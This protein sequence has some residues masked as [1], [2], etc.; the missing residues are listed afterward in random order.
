LS[1]RKSHDVSALAKILRGDGQDL[2][3]FPD[4]ED[5]T[6]FAVQYRYEAYDSE[7]EIDRDEAIEKTRTFLAHVQGILNSTE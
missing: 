3:K 7:D 5:Y 1:I 6:V 2:G 4:L